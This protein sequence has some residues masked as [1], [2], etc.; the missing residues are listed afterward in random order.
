MAA[1]A[2]ARTAGAETYAADDIAA[3]ETSL[4]R[5]DGFVAQ[6]DY[7]Q[8][9][10]SALEARDRGFEAAKAATA[11]QT[12]LRAEA[13]RLLALL[14][15]ALK[16]ADAELKAPRPASAAKRAARL[17]QT[18]QATALAMQ[19]ARAQLDS[20]ELTKAVRRL[21]DAIAAL[22]RDTAALAAIARKPK[23]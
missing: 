14:D 9:L 10:N 15:A 12:E 11:R 16:T 1:I 8:A 23:K 19:E 13:S 17:R 18:R 20:G 4:K 22:N 2:A 7:K 6:R 3:A 5:Y 21:G